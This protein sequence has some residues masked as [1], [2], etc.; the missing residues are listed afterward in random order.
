MIRFFSM[1]ILNNII[2]KILFPLKNKV[3]NIHLVLKETFNVLNQS[4]WSENDIIY[5]IDLEEITN[6]Q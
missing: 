4:E 3:T 5:G 2:L 1:K 6:P